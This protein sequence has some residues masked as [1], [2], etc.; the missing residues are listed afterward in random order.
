MGRPMYVAKVIW[1]ALCVSVLIV[2]LYNYEPNTDA[3]DMVMVAMLTAMTVLSF[4]SGLIAFFGVMAIL[5]LLISIFNAIINCC[6]EASVLP[7][8]TDW[9]LL[10]FLWL[11]TFVAGYFQWFWLLPRLSNKNSKLLR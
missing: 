7:A 5:F 10:V 1:G 8:A 2:T 11:I 3:G 9:V 4:P 6:P